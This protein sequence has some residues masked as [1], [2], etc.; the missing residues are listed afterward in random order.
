MLH[1]TIPIYLWHVTVYKF[2]NFDQND[3]IIMILIVVPFGIF[4]QQHGQ[5]SQYEVDTS[6]I[7]AL[8]EQV[9]KAFMNSFTLC[10]NIIILIQLYRCLCLP[11]LP[12]ILF[13]AQNVCNELFSVL[14]LCIYFHFNQSTSNFDGY[15]TSNDCRLISSNL[16]TNTVHTKLSL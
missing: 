6:S 15:L 1:L 11:H 9:Y 16:R 2:Y 10:F 5:Y 3:T 4:M 13:V 8:Y 12:R 7:V 14:P